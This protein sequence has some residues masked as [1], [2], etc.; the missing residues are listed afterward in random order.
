MALVVWPGKLPSGKLII[1]DTYLPETVTDVNSLKKRAELYGCFRELNNS[2]HWLKQCLSKYQGSGSFSLAI[3]FLVRRPFNIIGSQS[4]IELCPYVVGIR[5]PDLFPDSGSMSVRPAAHRHAIGRPLLVQMSGGDPTS[6]RT[7]WTLVGAGSLGSKLALHLTRAGNGPE[8]VLDKSAMT[9]H[10]AARHALIPIM[11]DMQI[12]LMDA[13][14]RVLCNAL[15]GLDQE[16]TPIVADAASVLMSKDGARRVW[17][18]RSWAVVNATASPVVRETLAATKLMPTRVV[19]TSL[20]AS[21]LVGMI[22][23][24]GP[25]R[26][27]NTVDLM[28]EYYALL[29]EDSTLAQVVFDSDSAV[30]RQNI[31]QGCGSLT[32]PM[33]DGRLS[34]FAAGM[35][36]YLLAKQRD[37]LPLSV[38][39]I[40]IGRLSGDGF[41]L[42][43]QITQVPPMTVASTINRRSWSVHIHP[44]ALKKIRDET[45]CWQE[46]ETGGV[47]M[48]RLSDATR[49]VSIVDVLEPPEDSTRSADEFVL[50]TKGLRQ[51]IKT[52]SDVVDWSLYC[53]GT[54]H[55]HLSPSGPS[56]TDRSTAEAI[57]LARLSPS[58]SLIH[59]PIGFSAFL[60]DIGDARTG[61]E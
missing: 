53:L 22:T 51:C 47:L 48:G 16:T 30:S 26:N 50:G 5:L 25:N 59:T 54:W 49:T 15:R 35:A 57:A 40:L 61:G 4:P 6:E 1:N 7:C 12:L 39:E 24:E 8:V 55:S 31:G 27:P 56:T 52:Y 3:V 41:G 43:W 28:A 19:E 10:N 60:A 29:R 34:L 46:V 32:M 9:P 17:S 36:E 44:R 23:V 18:K 2:L 37:G 58:I 20:F 11:D 21:G 14:A 13:K 42:K 45:A 38:G 33:S